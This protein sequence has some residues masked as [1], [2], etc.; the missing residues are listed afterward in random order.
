MNHN[1]A[2]T[3]RVGYLRRRLKLTEYRYNQAY[4]TILRTEI[5]EVQTK[6]VLF[7]DKMFK[8]L[9]K[10]GYTF[11]ETKISAE[12]YLHLKGKRAGKDIFGVL[13]PGGE[14][15]MM[16][17]PEKRIVTHIGIPTGKTYMNTDDQFLVALMHPTNPE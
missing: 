14:A 10:M 13:D 8:K 15:M 5:K 17:L 3:L 6:G 7:L 4:K 1:K 9:H 11:T 12:G 16:L 2:I